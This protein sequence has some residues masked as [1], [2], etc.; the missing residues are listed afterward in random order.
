MDKSFKGLEYL[1]F[2]RTR[3]A[4]SERISVDQTDLA[5]DLE[6]VDFA[7]NQEDRCACVLLLDVSYSMSGVPIDSLNQGIRSFKEELNKDNYAR[8]RVEVAIV[9]FGSQADVVQKFITADQF[10]PPTLRAYGSTSMGAGINLALDIIEARKQRYK[11]HGVC[12]YRPW[13]LMITDGAPTDDISYATHRIIEAEKSKKAIFFAVGTEG[14]S[15]DIL[16]K[17]SVRLPIKLN[18]LNFGELFEWLSASLS[19]VSQS[20]IGDQVAL[21][22]PRASESLTFYT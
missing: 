22:D 17:I 15:M 14:A 13:I 4:M 16:S 19:S 18:E 12:Y 11:Q 2:A 8:K 1:Y 20:R 3:L 9:T 5:S 6:A 21:P 7:E 10:T